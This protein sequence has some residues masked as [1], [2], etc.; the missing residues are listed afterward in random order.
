MA[1]EEGES[2]DFSLAQLANVDMS[3]IQEVS[4]EGLPAGLYTFRGVEGKLEKVD[5]AKEE[6]RGKISIQCEVVEVKSITERGITAEDYP[7]YIG[8][9]HRENFWIVPEKPEEGL[10]IAVKFFRAVGVDTTGK[11]LGGCI[12]EESGEPIV[13]II[14]EFA[15]GVEFA[16]KITKKPRKGDPATKDSVL[17]PIDVRKPEKKG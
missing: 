8:K 6:K 15:D 1:D 13:G 5:N 16:G 12:D 4:F 10:G 17:S 2:M 11:P 7:D 14:D 3:D 9:K